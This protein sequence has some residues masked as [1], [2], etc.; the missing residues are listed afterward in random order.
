MM[1]L[2]ERNCRAVHDA[3]ACS[4]GVW[5]SG[6]FVGRHLVP[7]R[8][9]RSV[10]AHGGACVTTGTES[11]ALVDALFFY[12]PRRSSRRGAGQGS[13]GDRWWADDDSPSPRG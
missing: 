3:A 12:L 8:A 7:R 5:C 1:I 13:R 2:Q 4:G 6:R 9:A 11:V 10:C